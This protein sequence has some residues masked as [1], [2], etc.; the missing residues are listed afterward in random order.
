[1][2]GGR[3]CGGHDWH[4][5]GRFLLV[6]QNTGPERAG[7]PRRRRTVSRRGRGGGGESLPPA[8]AG[9]PPSVM[10]PTA[11]AAEWAPQGEVASVSAAAGPSIAATFGGGF[12][13]WGLTVKGLTAGV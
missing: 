4:G 10:K 2:V 13:Q 11:A 5:A 8:P 6:R 1:M 7:H 9:N 3:T 12:Q